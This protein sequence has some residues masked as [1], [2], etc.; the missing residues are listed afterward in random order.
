MDAQ[1]IREQLD[2]SLGEIPEGPVG[3]AGRG[4]LFGAANYFAVATLNGIIPVDGLDVGFEIRSSSVQ[5]VQDGE[6]HT[7]EILAS[8]KRLAEFVARFESA[9]TNIDFIRHNP[10]VKS[11]EVSKERDT[12]NLYRVVTIFPEER[13]GR[14]FRDADIDMLT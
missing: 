10:E 12:L 5:D 4:K 1:K 9:P 13:E 8:N 3:F 7:F 2:S 11:S 14:D 6:Q